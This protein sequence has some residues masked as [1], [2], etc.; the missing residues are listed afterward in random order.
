MND[1]PAFAR[2]QD[3]TATS[4]EPRTMTTSNALAFKRRD[5]RGSTLVLICL[6]MVMIVAMVAFAV[7]AGRMYLVR[8]QLQTAVDAGALAAT[9]K[10]KEKG[11]IDAAVQAA[12]D[13]VQRNRVG[14]L[15]TVPKEAISIETGVW[16]PDTKTFDTAGSPPGAVRVSATMANEPLF[17]APVMGQGTF[18]L[19]RA[20]IANAGGKPM[21][22][23][24]TL[25]LSAS[26][27]QDG[28]IEALQ[29]A[30]PEFVSAI[31]TVGS[32]DRIGVMGYGAIAGQYNPHG[33]GQTGVPYTSAPQSLYPSGDPWVGV[34]EGPISG[35]LNVVKSNLTPQ[36]LQAGKYNGWTP[37]GAALRD[38]ACY[39]DSNARADVEKIIVL[40]S[41]G[42][43][44]KP[45]GNAN[46]YAY[47]MADYAKA[48]NIKVYTISL[49]NGADD[50]LMQEIASRTGGD[51]F[52][53]AGNGSSLTQ[54]L[55]DAF[56]HIVDSLK[57]TQL[58]Q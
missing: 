1:L 13:F 39:L 25:D 43:A 17:F 16:D 33:F 24:M 32:Q 14:F 19:P 50:Q 44:N 6:L 23:M 9:L 15:I 53:A 52:K 3:F 2:R 22:I 31:Q 38:S 46:G 57:R 56:R 21:D 27:R 36:V 28:R 47:D 7:D 45:A 26:M 34:L 58:V 8:A 37:T 12:D 10:L 40:M 49:G 18:S 42:H 41:D 5:R 4:G 54:S 55:Q 51:F 11:D 30:A 35:D 48:N 29:T 20:A